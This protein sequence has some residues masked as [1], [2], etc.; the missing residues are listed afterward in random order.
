MPRSYPVEFG[1]KVL[2]LLEAGWSLAQVAADLGVSDQTIYNWREQE[3]IDSGQKPGLSSSDQAEL[4]AAR[5]RIA[6]LEAELAATKRA[7][8]L[9]KQVVPP[10]RR[11]EAIAVMA[12]EGHAVQVT[13]HVLG[14]SESGL[15]A[16]RSRPPSARALRHAMLT[17]VITQIHAA[18]K[19]TYGIRRVHAELIL[20]R[21]MTV[22]RH[23]VALLMHRAGLKGL[24]GHKRRRA[25]PQTPSA[26]DLVDRRFERSD[27]DRLWVSDITEHP[28][29]EGKVYCAVVLDTFSR[30]VVG[31]S[32]DAAQTA[33][34]VTNAIDM[35]IH[36]RAPAADSGTIIHSDS[37]YV[38][39]GYFRA[40]CSL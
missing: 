23:A 30:R 26:A 1:R 32:I 6:E 9:L 22:G 13:C 25:V 8:E 27:P 11:F 20:G 4:I 18:S 31:W 7:A 12:A 24:P 3:L 39:A 5:R 21:G 34:L 14:V 40:I 28:T 10:K 16:W 35:A 2:D 17:E 37:E 29:R 15:Y 38:V 19:S 36:N 33:I